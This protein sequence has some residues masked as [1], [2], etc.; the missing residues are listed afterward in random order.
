MTNVRNCNKEFEKK[1]IW[2]WGSSLLYLR[3]VE[4][5][6]AFDLSNLRYSKIS[7]VMLLGIRLLES[8]ENSNHKEHKYALRPNAEYLNS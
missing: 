4:L 2:G 5:S 3:S 6:K 7:V 1:K 8:R